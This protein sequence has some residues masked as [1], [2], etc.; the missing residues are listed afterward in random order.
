M[1]HFCL[2]NI[3]RE[4]KG[5]TV[6]KTATKVFIAS[7]LLFGVFGILLILMSPPSRGRGDAGVYEFLQTCIGVTVCVILSS[8]ALSVAGKYLMD[9]QGKPSERDGS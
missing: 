6:Q 2:V 8:F 3:N 5:M 7:S 9:D 1:I 4:W